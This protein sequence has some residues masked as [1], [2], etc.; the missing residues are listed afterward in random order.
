MSDQVQLIKE[1]LNIVDVIGQYVKL[2]K[3]G[4]NYKGLSPFN[5]EKTP[6]FFV[7]PDK[8]MYYD[9]SSGQGGDVFSFIERMEGLDFKGALTMLAERAGVELQQ[10]APGAK[11]A[12]ERLYSILEEVTRYYQTKLSENTGARAYLEKRGVEET[13]MRNFRL[14]FAEDGWQTLHDHLLSQKYTEMEME[15]AGLIK[16]GEKGTYYDRFRS[17]IMFPI[18]DSSGRVVAFSGRIFGEA[19]R[20]ENNAKY[21][22]SPETRLFDKSRILYGF[23]RAKQYI[24]KYDFTILVEGQM[25]L[26]LSHQIGYGNTVAVSGTGLTEHHLLL[27]EKLSKKMVLAFDADRAGV[28][29]AGRGAFIALKRGIDVKVAIVPEGKDPADCILEDPQEWKRAVKNSK[30]VIDFFMD[31]LIAESKEKG[32]DARTCV[33]RAQESVLPF[34]ASIQSASER[35]HFSQSVASALNIHEEAVRED[36]HTLRTQNTRES[37]TPPQQ[38]M[39]TTQQ[40][41]PSFSRKTDLE[42]TLLGFIFMHEASDHDVLEMETV[43]KTANTFGIPLTELRVR[44]EDEKEHLIEESNEKYPTSHEPM[45]IAMSLLKDLGRIYVTDNLDMVRLL[46]LEAEHEGN[47]EQSALLAKK[48]ADLSKQREALE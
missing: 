25:D 22:N 14:G 10:E 5:K 9:F 4:K 13:T 26:V 6:S 27:L 37:Y 2:T 12:R 43:Q 39:Q 24:R 1:R 45:E 18:M 41:T 23:H 19:A 36:V 42:K 17:R 21:L 20:D 44:Y 48:V 46:Q 47:E 33:T 30:H 3:A 31:R 29:S 8:G 28:A 34:I 11:D 35:A 15:Q 40:V 16:K 38:T 32:W 7:S